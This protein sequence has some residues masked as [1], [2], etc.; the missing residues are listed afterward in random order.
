MAGGEA[1]ERDDEGSP[2]GRLQRG[3]AVGVGGGAFDLDGYAGQGR[4]GGRVHEDAFHG[5][6]PGGGGTSR[7]TVTRGRR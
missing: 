1:D 7:S 5:A 3:I 4:A 6:D 2:H